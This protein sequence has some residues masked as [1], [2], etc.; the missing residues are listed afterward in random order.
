MSS[1]TRDDMR[2]IF[3]WGIATG[4]QLDVADRLISDGVLDVKKLHELGDE[5]FGEYFE[6]IKAQ[7]LS[8]QQ[9]RDAN[10]EI[11]EFYKTGKGNQPI[12]GLI[13]EK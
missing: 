4:A 8:K 13:K 11:E 12:P 7:K 10:K 1:Y 5:L 2:K 9:G 6:R 3:L